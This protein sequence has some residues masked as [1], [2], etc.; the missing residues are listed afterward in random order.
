M[1]IPSGINI[2]YRTDRK[3]YMRAYYAKYR[4]KLLAD[5]KARGAKWRAENRQYKRD[6]ARRICAERK[7]AA[8]ALFGSICCKCGFSDIR[9]L[10]IDHVEQFK[11]TRQDRAKKGEM[12]EKLYARLLK[13]SATI[14]DYQLLCANCN[15]IKRHENGE[16][17]RKS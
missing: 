9:A 4:D 12:G 5:T 13:G 16:C 6:R 11:G 14:T 7:E 17:R 10:Q 8:F 15:W 3:G 1:R 2:D